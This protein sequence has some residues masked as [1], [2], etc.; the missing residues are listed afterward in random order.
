MS[1]L[2][3]LALLLIGFSVINAGFLVLFAFRQ[4]MQKVAYLSTVLLII[5]PSIQLLNF[6][7]LEFGYTWVHSH[8]YNALLFMVAPSF[9]LLSV[10]LLEAKDFLPSQWWLH[11]WP[12]LLAFMLP[13]NF[14]LPLAFVVGAG[15]LVQVALNIYALRAQRSRFRLELLGLALI[16]V[17]A[18]LIILLGVS[19]SLVSD[20]VFFSLYAGA[21]GGGFVLVSVVLSLSPQL[22][23]EVAEAARETYAVSTLGKVDCETTLQQLNQLMHTSKRYQDAELDLPSLSEDLG[24]THYQLSELINTRLGKSFSRYLREQRVEAAKAQL[25]NEPKATVLGIGLEVGFSSQSNFYE[26]FREVVG[27]TPGQF[28]KLNQKSVPE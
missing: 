18:I 9:Y 24:L 1:L 7:Y 10:L 15:Y 19:N 26:A 23:T 22:P 4:S 21:I 27:M 13:A 3:A 28:R 17:L 8:F 16:L 2:K 6:A 5:L 25:I 12:V 11:F 20:P 14:G